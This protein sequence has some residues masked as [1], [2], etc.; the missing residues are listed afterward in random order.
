MSPLIPLRRIFTLRASDRFD[1]GI[2]DS[3]AQPAF[4]GGVAAAEPQRYIRYSRIAN[5]SR[6]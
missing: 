1:S 6:K 2:C 3:G 5:E 4:V